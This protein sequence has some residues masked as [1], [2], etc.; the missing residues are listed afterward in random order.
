VLRLGDG[1]VLKVSHPHRLRTRLDVALRGSRARRAFRHGHL[2]E[3]HGI[4]TPRVLAFAEPSRSLSSPRSLLIV[5]EVPEAE[6]A[7]AFLARISDPVRQRAFLE[8]CGAWV[9]ALHRAGL[10]H[11]DLK[12]RNVLRTTS[13]HVTVVD[14]DGLR[15]PRRLTRSRRL[16]DLRRMLRSGREVAALGT[17]EALRFLRGYR[18]ASHHRERASY[19]WKKLV[20]GVG[21]TS[22]T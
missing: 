4:A 9:G 2:L 8:A 10:S 21:R 18:R 1:T 3:L 7:T 19:L 15:R 12:G 11:R 5:E 20:D 22:M 17:R 16:R 14:L 13:D 6:H